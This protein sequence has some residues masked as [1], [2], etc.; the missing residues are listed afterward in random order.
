MDAVDYDVCI[1]GAGS[2][3][4]PLAAHAKRRGKIAVHMGGATQILFG[5]KGRRWDGHAEISQ[6][7]NDAWVRPKTTEVPRAACDVEGGCY[8]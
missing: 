6:L 8:W 7:Y 1:I 4:L 3:G 5:I 2:Y